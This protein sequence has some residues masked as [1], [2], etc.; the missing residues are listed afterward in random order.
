MQIEWNGEVG[1]ETVNFFK[2]RMD[3]ILAE[4]VKDLILDLCEVN[5]LNSMGLGVLA[6][7][8]K[9]IQKSGGRMVISRLSPS[10]EELF[11]LTR[12]TKVFN[13]RSSHEEALEF[14]RM[15]A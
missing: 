11:E 9:K 12:I 7:T 14:F 3:G 13:I 1:P 10:V 15:S 2:D 6:A 8:L 5:Y 4:G